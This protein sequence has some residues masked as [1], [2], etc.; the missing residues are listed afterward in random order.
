M[1]K[2]TSQTINYKTME[3]LLNRDVLNR[4][5]RLFANTVSFVASA[6]ANRDYSEEYLRRWLKSQQ[7]NE[8]EMFHFFNK[9]IMMNRNKV[10]CDY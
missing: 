7:L 9:I 10:H 1:G 5:E 8:G 4:D 6:V 3:E 2:I